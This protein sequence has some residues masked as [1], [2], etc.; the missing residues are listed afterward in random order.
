MGWTLHLLPSL[1]ASARAEHLHLCAVLS[2]SSLHLQLFV[3]L[4]PSLHLHLG[5]VLASSSLHLQLFVEL[6]PSL[7]HL[8]LGA[9]L[10]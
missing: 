2:S 5:A 8:Q 10:A 3:V 4:D 1:C 9:W 7:S 6:D